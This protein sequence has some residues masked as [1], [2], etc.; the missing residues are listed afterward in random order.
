MIP[1]TLP[2]EVLLCKES[3]TAH[4]LTGPL[5]SMSAH[6][7][8]SDCRSHKYGLQ[9]GSVARVTKVLVQRKP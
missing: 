9:E 2:E 3:L 4:A 6:S 1:G 5:T 8:T 7:V